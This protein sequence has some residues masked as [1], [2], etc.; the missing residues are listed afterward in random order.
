MW[1][2]PWSQLIKKQCKKVSF[3]ARWLLLSCMM[4]AIIAMGLFFCTYRVS[5]V[6]TLRIDVK[7]SGSHIAYIMP[8]ALQGKI[9]S[10]GTVSTGSI[11]K[12]NNSITPSSSLVVQKKQLHGMV[13]SK[14]AI[15]SVDAKSKVTSM[16]NSSVTLKKN[17]KKERAKESAVKKSLLPNEKNKKMTT[18]IVKE[19]IPVSSSI[20]PS[21]L[22][23]VKADAI[24]SV[25]SEAVL[26]IVSHESVHSDV[27]IIP[28]EISLP[29][30][31][32]TIVA[33]TPQDALYLALQEEIMRN[34]HPPVGVDIITPCEL[35]VIL[36]D[37]SRVSNVEMIQSS[38]VLMY[39]VTVRASVASVIFPSWARNKTIVLQYN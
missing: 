34:W 33:L 4:H 25:K 15:K 27:L 29:L 19:S 5:E 10:G 20:M 11:N 32:G 12:K 28:D 26:P 39:D 24:P 14:S 22:S 1:Y 18:P 17:N 38:G 2:L 31:D 7:K 21:A 37:Q 9:V 16:R 30:G 36:D 6:I 23:A 13:R 3:W 35:K 8:Q